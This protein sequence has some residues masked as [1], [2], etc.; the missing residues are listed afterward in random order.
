[1][2]L[3]RYKAGEFRIGYE[4]SYF[5]PTSVNHSFEWSDARLSALLERASFSLGELNS[6]SRFVPGTEMFIIMHTFQEAVTSSKIEGTQTNIEEALIDLTNVDPERRD[7]WR[8]VNNYVQAMNQAIAELKTLPLSNRLI[9]NA[10]RTLL[11]S[12]RGEHKSPGEFRTSQNWIGGRNLAEATFVPPF[13][14]LLPE[15]MGDLE[16]F[17][18]NEDINI[19]HLIRIAIA[20]YQFETIH[21]FLDGNGRIGRLLITLYLVSRGV[22][23]QPLLYLSAYL[24]R[25]KAQYYDRLMQVRE[26][27]DLGQW[28]R[29][30][31]EGVAQTA[32]EA[33]RT[34]Q[35]MLTLKERIEKEQ[36][37]RMGRRTQTAMVFLHKLFAKPVVTIKDVEGMAGLTFRAASDL[38]KIFE[39]AGILTETTG[40][41]RNRVFVFREYVELFA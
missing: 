25:N 7:D 12:V 29:F 28:L 3:D 32:S 9:R 26:T 34:L 20:H 4:Y 41:Q 15:L 2:D 38:V 8:E 39:E 27:H 24:E 19:P 23:D 11:S 16:L 18:N 17:L 33:G 22:L 13:Q 30:F 6:F 31:L 40:Y 37:V 5:V 36:I 14:D 35:S 1:M 21:P 10:H